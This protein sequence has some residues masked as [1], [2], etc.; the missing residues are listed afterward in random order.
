MQSNFG[1]DY[2][3][4]F[5]DNESNEETVNNYD[6]KSQ[7]ELRDDDDDTNG[8][9]EYLEGH[10]TDYIPAPTYDKLWDSSNESNTNIERNQAQ[11]VIRVQNTIPISDDTTQVVIL[12]S[13]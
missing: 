11:V 4:E 7:D 5:E 6:Y 8:R 2:S 13:N 10:S 1:G 3:N 12:Y 9:Y